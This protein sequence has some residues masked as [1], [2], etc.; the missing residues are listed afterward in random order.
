MLKGK[1]AVITGGSRGIGK[2]IA[3]KLAEMGA[4]IVVNYRSSSIE[5]VLNEIRALGVNAIGVQGDIS[6]SEDADKLIKTAHSEFG[7][8]DIL[9]NNAGITKDGLLMRM[10][11]AD[12]DS[13]INTN[14]KGTFNT[15][16]SASSIMMKQRS[17]KIINLTSVVGITGNAG[18]A[19]Y[20]SSKA[21]VIGLTKSVAREL[22]SRGVTCNAVAPGFIETDMTEALSDKVKE[23]TLSTIPLKKLGTTEDVANLVGFLASDLS[24][25]ITG[26]VI[27]VDGGM[28]M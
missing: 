2:A 5:E 14:L 9:V 10:K 12:F 22:A 19:N 17:G 15:I 1:T 21:G 25:Y 18:Q 11:D 4:N 7:S 6:N 13:V 16:R 20:A 24:N 23:A 27:N 3:L 26:Q 28:V 8:V